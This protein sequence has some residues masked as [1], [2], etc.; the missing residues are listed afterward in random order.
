[1]A[2]TVKKIITAV[3]VTLIMG[4][5]GI[6]IGAMMN[7]EGY[8]GVIFSIASMGAFILHSIEK[9]NEHK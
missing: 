6:Y 5:I 4:Y 7:L 1:M 3:A 9:I 8:L 2:K